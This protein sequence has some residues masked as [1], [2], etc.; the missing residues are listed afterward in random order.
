MNRDSFLCRTGPRAHAG[1]PPPR[2]ERIVAAALRPGRPRAAT[3]R[4][5]MQA[6]AA[7][8]GVATGSVYRHFP[9]KGDLFAEVFRRASQRE[10]D[11]TRPMADRSPSRRAQRA[12]GRG[13]GVRA[14]RAGRAGARLRADRRAGRPGRGG[15]AARRSAA[16]TR[17]FARALA[18]RRAR[19]RAAR[20]RLRRS[21]PRRSSARSREALVGPLAAPRRRAPHERSSPTC[22]V[23]RAITTTGSPV[24]RARH[25]HDV[26]NQ[27]VPFED[28][29]LFEADLALREALEREGGGWAVDRVRDTGARGGLG[30]GAGARPPRRA[31]RAAAA[32]PRPLRP[33]HRPGRARPVLALAAARR[34]RARDPRRCRGATRS[35]ARTSRAAALE[36][37]WTQANAGVMCPVSMTY[38]AVP[39]LR[40]DPSWPPSGSR[41]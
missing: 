7:R 31:Q 30:R 20:A 11:V 29:N 26:L 12:R 19:R 36:L 4:P 10:L 5:S 3:P 6:V 37:L 33:P 18:R 1:A 28:V 8:A 22:P 24:S 15:R 16:P 13:R 32:H 17:P 40:V 25:T 41:G 34:G 27:S 9:S 14:P 21:R 35:R 39:A 2:V 23:L 38:S